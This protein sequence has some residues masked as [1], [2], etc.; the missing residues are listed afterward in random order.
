MFFIIFSI[1]RQI[2]V[3]CPGS[4]HDCFLLHTFI[5]FNWIYLIMIICD[6]IAY[7]LIE[8]LTELLTFSNS[9]NQLSPRHWIRFASKMLQW[10]IS[11]DTKWVET[12]WGKQSESRNSVWLVSH[13]LTSELCRLHNLYTCPSLPPGTQVSGIGCHPSSADPV[14]VSVFDYFN[15]FLYISFSTK[16]FP[17]VSFCTVTLQ[18]DRNALKSVVVEGERRWA[19][20]GSVCR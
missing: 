15:V 17:V 19:V 10:R 9:V 2:K 6:A 3:L 4:G 13:R 14:H 5:Q 12:F 1:S 8:I 20:G 11:Y 18:S 7:I 16:G